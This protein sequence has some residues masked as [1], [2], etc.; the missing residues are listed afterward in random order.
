MK[1]SRLY[2]RLA[3]CIVKGSAVSSLRA[4]ETKI[5]KNSLRYVHNYVSSSAM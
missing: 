2:N 4:P 3:N 1:P 5:K